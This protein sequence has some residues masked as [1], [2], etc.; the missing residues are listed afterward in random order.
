LFTAIRDKVKNRLF[1]GLSRDLKARLDTLPTESHQY[2]VTPM[3][4]LA[5]RVV[6]PG[7]AGLPPPTVVI[8]VHRPR[9]VLRHALAAAL[10]DLTKTYG[11]KQ[12]TWHRSHAVSHLESLTGVVGPSATEPFVDR[13]SWVQQVAFS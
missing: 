6:R 10:A 1:H 13:G 11:A 5:L 9:A 7:W 2:D 4:N 3:D 12:S 8:G